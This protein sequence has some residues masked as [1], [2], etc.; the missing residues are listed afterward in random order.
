MGTLAAA[1]DHRRSTSSAGMVTAPQVRPAP[2]NAPDDRLI[3]PP[4]IFGAAGA[5][6]TAGATLDSDL[7]PRIPVE[8]LFRPP[9]PSHMPRI[10]RLIRYAKAERLHAQQGR[11][12]R[13]SQAPTDA[14]TFAKSPVPPTSHNRRALR[15]RWHTERRI[16]RRSSRSNRAAAGSISLLAKR[17][18]FKPAIK[19]PMS[20]TL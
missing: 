4:S 10:R 7:P 1:I 17:Q 11:P 18:R 3:T 15:I 8:R 6:D 19:G 20:A 9:C 13:A 12:H 5:S 2:L 16:R 14:D